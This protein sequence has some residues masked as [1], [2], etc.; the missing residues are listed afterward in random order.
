MIFSVVFLVG[1]AAAYAELPEFVQDTPFVAKEHT[2]CIRTF[3]KIGCFKAATVAHMSLFIDDSDPKSPYNGGYLVDQAQFDKSTHSLACR[4]SQ[5][6]RMKG[7]TYFSIRFWG[8]CYVGKDYKN[9]QAMVDDPHTHSSP[10]CLDPKYQ[11]CNDNHNKECLG[12]QNADYIYSIYGGDNEDKN[13]DGGYGAWSKWTECSAACDE[14]VVTRERSCTKPVPKGKGADC[15]AKGPATETK[16]CRIKECKVDGGWTQWSK[17]S[18]CSRSCGGGV[19]R[20]Q[21]T[22]RAPLPKN[23]G[24]YCAGNDL[25]EKPCMEQP[26]PQHGGYSQWGAFGPCTATCG[27]GQ[28]SRV[29]TCTQPAPAHGGRT[30]DY[31]GDA[32]E[33][34]KCHLRHCPIDGGYSA[35][36]PFAPCS[37]T[38]GT[39][40]KTRLRM[41]TNPS[42]QHGGKY[43]MGTPAE[44]EQCNTDPCPIDG[45][46]TP[47]GEWDTCSVT[48][49]G[50]TTQ[51]RR[52]CTNPAPDHGGD[53]CDGVGMERKR[54][55]THNCPIPGG[56][57]EWSQFGEC[58]VSCGGGTKTRERACTNPSPKY[59][60]A[61][62]AGA[63][64]DTEKCNTQHCP[65]DGGYT[66]F[67][68]WSKCSKSCGGGTQLRSRTCTNP[69]PQYGGESCLILGAPVEVRECETQAC[70]RYMKY[71]PWSKCS[72]SCA[73]GVQKRTRACYA[74][75]WEARLEDCAHLGASEETRRCETQPCPVHG[76]WGSWT[77]W[78]LCSEACGK[79]H[80][81]KSRK[82]NNPHPAYGGNKCP[83]YKSITAT[84]QIKPCAIHGAWTAWSEFQTCTKSCGG[85]TKTRLR[86]CSN[87]AP[88]HGGR[89]CFGSAS[90]TDKCNTHHCPV[91]GGWTQ[92][93]MWRKC[94]KSCGGG[95]TYRQRSCTAPKPMYGGDYCPGAPIQAKQCG[96]IPCPING[97]WSAYG[98]FGPCTKSCGGG[99]KFSLRY[100]N[101]PQPQYNGLTCA[102]A[103]KKYQNCNTHNCPVDG[104]YSPWTKW[105]QCSFTCGG[106][107][108]IRTRKCTE[109]KYGG[110]PCSVLGKDKDQRECNTELCPLM[111]HHTKIECEGGK[112]TL[113]KCTL[114]G[115]K[116]HIL[117]GRYGR[118]QHWICGNVAF[119]NYNC[120]LPHGKGTE[121]ATK[122][123][124][125]KE[126]CTFEV[127][128]ET[129]GS[130]PCPG[131]H[132]YA[133]IMYQCYG[134]RYPD[135]ADEE[136]PEIPL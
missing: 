3:S 59:G 124:E 26:C 39:G 79:G 135:L 11:S 66:D 127:T 108:Q 61:P 5:K 45:G 105:S 46:W 82:C 15:S 17:Y 115:G 65:I 57:T 94:T 58:T 109:P 83:G 73:G 89:D 29:R 113:D 95:R 31:L 18:V 122:L 101:Q 43:C 33:N 14:G 85:G 121:V 120:K 130:N 44:V 53:D 87:P 68:K 50:G 64:T 111:T 102:G 104:F 63:T 42:P 37:K 132:K 75:G 107:T 128:D 98:V 51:R 123:C 23:G 118:E 20:R 54:C 74:S 25:E 117:A 2:T 24:A 116:I 10:S 52:S 134:G 96:T 91:D 22:C 70:A 86:A 49:G 28:K 36:G 97:G 47:Y 80:K 30:C 125:G 131:T 19:S 88:Q 112:A 119:W 27:D 100:C 60:G 84:C 106:G 76:N 90:H 133:E 126:S 6:A 35:W 41:C 136:Q 110:K 78:T 56:F 8:M 16:A 32:E 71:G 38:C 7:Y 1:L 13:I 67:G 21:R 99:T 9:V 114:G 12:F 77:P 81:T 55:N 72:K 103:D 62:C 129:F 93:G 69:K 34:V 92:W 4:C 48:C 40:I